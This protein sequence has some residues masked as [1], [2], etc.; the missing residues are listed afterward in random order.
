MEKIVVFKDK[1]IRRTMHN[2]EWWFVIVDVIGAPH[3]LSE[4]C[5]LFKRYETKG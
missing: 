1:D 5:G 4:S 2:D 3:R